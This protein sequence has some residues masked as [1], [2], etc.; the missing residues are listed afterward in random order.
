MS[1][2]SQ[3][4][5]R[6]SVK[7]QKLQSVRPLSSTIVTKLRERFMLEM[8]Y[9]SNAIE[10]NSLTL[11]ETYLVLSEGIT[12]K[13]KSL[14][15]HLEA[16][17]HHEALEFIFQQVEHDAKHTLTQNLIR[18]LQ[19][20][21]IGTIDISVAGI[22][23][24]VEVAITASTHQPPLA[25]E[26][27]SK[28]ADLITWYR[29]NQHKIPIIELAALLHHKLVNIHPFADGNGRTAR[30]LMNIVLLQAGYP[31]VIVLKSD[32][33]KYYQTLAQA[34]GG[35]VAPF[36]NFVAR[37]VERSLDMYLETIIKNQP[38]SNKYVTLGILAEKFNVTQ[39]HLNLLARQGKI[40][41]H[42]QDRV[43]LSSSQAINDY[44]ESRQRQA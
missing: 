6:L 21:V 29:Q 38:D 31:L 26:V 22:Y 40:V 16:K 20:L 39:K 2:D 12:I 28:M 9:N 23:R 34:D 44:M 27:P 18:Q 36:V 37:A 5:Q 25:T 3:F 14:K 42:K 30:L 24:D 11:K 13:G 43:W 19:S 8:T 1:L 41:A 7:H 10:G 15:D 4:L 33:Q 35:N 17:N 32:R